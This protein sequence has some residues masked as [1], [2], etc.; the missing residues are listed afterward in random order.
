MKTHFVGGMQVKLCLCTSVNEVGV[1]AD[2]RAIRIQFP[3][4]QI[5]KAEQ[6]RARDVTFSEQEE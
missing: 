6:R 5:D 2:L 4:T 1:A 3:T